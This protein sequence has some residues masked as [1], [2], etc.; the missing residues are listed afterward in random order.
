M[1]RPGIAAVGWPKNGD[2]ITPENPIGFTWLNRFWRRYVQLEAD[3]LVF[4]AAAAE[5]A[6]QISRAAA[7][8]AHA[9]ESIIVG[10]PASAP[11]DRWPK[12]NA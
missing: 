3:A 2:V 6:Q 10:R 12:P 11:A 7:A 5:H 4:G 8:A 1:R 9:V